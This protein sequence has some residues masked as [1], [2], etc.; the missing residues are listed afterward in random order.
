MAQAQVAFVF[1]SFCFCHLGQ[2]ARAFFLTSEHQASGLREDRLLRTSAWS[3][4]IKISQS[5]GCALATNFPATRLGATGRYYYCGL[6]FWDFSARNTKSSWLSFMSISFVS[7][8]GPR[9]TSSTTSVF[10][11]GDSCREQILFANSRTGRRFQVIGAKCGAVLR[12]LHSENRT[13]RTVISTRHLRLSFF[14]I[15]KPIIR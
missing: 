1:S 4:A 2:N 13:L 9:A 5:V 6:S 11:F 14:F 3:A 10:V 8:H 12:S 7:G 15:L